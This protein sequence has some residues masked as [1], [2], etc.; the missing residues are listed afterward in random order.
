MKNK[1]LLFP[2]LAIFICSCTNDS[3]NDLLAPNSQ[4][5]TDE[6]KSITYV[7]NI[8]PIIDSNCISCHSNPPVNGAPFSLSS[9]AQVKNFTENGS[10]VLAISKQT[11]ETSA[12]PPAG[13]L[14]KASIDLISQWIEDGLLEE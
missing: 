8:K 9:Y 6:K 10:L 7:A 5:Q 3:E 1:R 2:L 12:M 13:R 4:E 14:P 11:G